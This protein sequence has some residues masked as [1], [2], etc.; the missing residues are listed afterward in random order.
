MNTYTPGDESVVQ[1]DAGATTL[2]LATCEWYSGAG[3][4]SPPLPGD[5][6]AYVRISDGG[7]YA[8]VSCD[9]KTSKT[10]LAGE[11]RI[12]ARNAAGEITATVHLKGTGEIEISQES[13]TASV[14]IDPAGA[15]QLSGT[16]VSLQV[17]EALGKFLQTLHAGVTA[18]VPAPNDGGLALKTA[19]SAWLLQTPP[20]P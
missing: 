3:D 18:W 7:Q 16:S 12:Y 19:L 9:D 2:D 6:V 11:K 13:G 15:I 1:V 14:I 20:G 8:A 5:S 4:D 10:A 17:G